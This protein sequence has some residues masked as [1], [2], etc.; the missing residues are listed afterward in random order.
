MIFLHPGSNAYEL[1]GSGD[2][3]WDID[4]WRPPTC[5]KRI[6][7]MESGGGGN[8]G[9]EWCL[10]HEDISLKIIGGISRLFL[11]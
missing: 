3:N 6:A 1:Q 7:V 4:R 10:V 9:V 5:E 11:A 8:T 2:R